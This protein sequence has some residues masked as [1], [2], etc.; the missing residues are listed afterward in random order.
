MARFSLKN[1]SITI[2][3]TDFSSDVSQVMLDIQQTGV[4]ESIT[5]GNDWAENT[6]SGKGRWSVTITFEV[7]G[8]STSQVE[9]QLQAIMPPPIG[10]DSNPAS[11]AIVIKAD[12]GSRVS[13]QS[14]VDGQRGA[15]SVSAARFRPSRPSRP[16][17]PNL[18]WRRCAHQG[19]L[20]NACG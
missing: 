19:N 7:D 13:V 15:I 16:V 3:G 4:T 11:Q 1:P 20:L 5:A 17:H 18:G 6:P 10:A 12:S 2:A 14:V 8:Y 9:G